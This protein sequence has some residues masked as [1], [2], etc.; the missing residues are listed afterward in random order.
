MPGDYPIEF[1]VRELRHIVDTDAM[2]LRRLPPPAPCLQPEDGCRD[3]L[4]AV[5]GRFAKQALGNLGRRLDVSGV[6][7]FPIVFAER[8]GI[9]A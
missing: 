2:V 7:F 4:R 1:L 8:L 3:R 9:D 5:G 6:E